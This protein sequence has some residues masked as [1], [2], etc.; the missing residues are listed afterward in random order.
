MKKASLFIFFHLCVA[1]MCQAV[2]L[3][4]VY[5]QSVE[6]DPLFK[7]AYSQFMS[8][9]EQ[10]PQ[11]QAALMPQLL[12]NGQ[13]S[14]NNINVNSG[15][16]QVKEAYNS[17]QWKLMA[18]QALFNYQSWAQM[19]Q[20]KATIKAAYA[21]YNDAAQD[22]ILRS[23]SAYLNVLYARDSLSYAEAKK[24]A[25]QRQLDQA[26]ERFNVG[27]EPITSVYDAQSAYDHST[28]DVIEGQNR[29]LNQQENLRKL[30]NHVYQDYAVLHHNQIPLISPEPN[31]K[32]E[33]IATSLRQ[34]Y[35]LLASKLTLQ[36]ARETI[37]AKNAG[38]WPVF[39]LQGTTTQTI[40]NNPG[41]FTGGTKADQLGS[42]VFVPNNQQ[43]S[44]IAIAVN[45]PFYQGGLIQSQTRQAQ[46]DFQTASEQ[47]EKAYRDV[48]VNS[49]I[50]FNTIVDGINKIK[51]DRQT[52]L[53]Q[54]NTV[55]STEAQF[56][57]GTRTMVDV[58]LA[59]QHLFE[60]QDQLAKDQYAHIN[61]VLN[62]KY[63][64]GTLNV[65]DL[66]EINSWLTRTPIK[67]N[68]EINNGS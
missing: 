52:V 5:Q 23:A 34:N 61:A 38:N 43:V 53:S 28:A 49:S 8:Q 1:S 62:L 39:S 20:A 30:T 37:N 18:S 14:M 29:L 33:W 48:V 4:D 65:I 16:F 9:R 13:A 56:L 22:L 2:D 60:A 21:N 32:E 57:V 46:F 17:Q 19:Q 24:R 55:Q 59:Q 26:T 11:A 41:G 42:N 66:Q 64:A 58:V 25:N 10:L 3:M 68:A 27:L 50:A 45:F 7:A 6:N 44:N 31:K 36:A 63:L 15:P 12:F 67:I 35:K 40:N 47:M 51:A 54:Q